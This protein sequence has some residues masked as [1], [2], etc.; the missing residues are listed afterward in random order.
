MRYG[1]I[2]RET[3]SVRYRDIR[4]VG[5]KQ[6]MVDRLLNIGLLEFAAAG[7]DDVDIRFSNVVDPTQLKARI[8]TLMTTGTS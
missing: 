2:A 3:L 7:T 4:S 5:L 8:Q 6:S 1:L